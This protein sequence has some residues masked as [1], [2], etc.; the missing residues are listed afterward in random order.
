MR[1]RI[2]PLDTKAESIVSKQLRS[3]LLPLF[4]F[5]CFFSWT[6]VLFFL[7]FS[8]Y[9]LLLCCVCFVSLVFFLIKEKKVHL[10]LLLCYHVHVLFLL[11]RNGVS[12]AFLFVFIFLFKYQ[13]TFPLFLL[14]S[15]ASFSIDSISSSLTRFSG[16]FFPLL[17]LQSCFSTFACTGYQ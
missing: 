17:S 6:V 8:L 16:S 3:T 10:L 2:V 14:P 5:I 1:A 9:W 12:I 15:H 7:G 4:L 13:L 11:A